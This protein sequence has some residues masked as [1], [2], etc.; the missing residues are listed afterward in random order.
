M[1]AAPRAEEERVIDWL[2]EERTKTQTSQH[3]LQIATDDPRVAVPLYTVHEAARYLGMPYET[4]RG[5]ARPSQGRSPLV[6]AFEASGR[7]ATIPFIGL[8]EA[9]VLQAARRA[10]VPNHR[11]RPGVEAVQTELGVQHAL[12]SR[13]LY[14]DGAEL[15]IQR[16][17]EE[18][19]L[20]VARTRQQQLSATVR[21]QLQ[22]ITYGGDGFAARLTLPAYQETEVVVDP[23]VAF[24]Y[25][26]VT[27]SGVRVKDVLDRFWAG[28][29]VDAI[30]YDFDLPRSQVEDLL[31]AE[32]RPSPRAAA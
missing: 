26:V 31:R 28:D 12:A 1:K 4:L 25:P 19:D 10:G 5:W 32:T 15:L 9:F 21:S 8:A 20:E 11:I 3:G 29:G 17:A 24:G 2:R 7:R 6:T 13:R 30:A 14:T 27:K 23:A 18:T 22:L 16:A